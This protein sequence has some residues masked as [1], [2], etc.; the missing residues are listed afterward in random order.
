MMTTFPS[1]W[2]LDHC[3]YVF[4]IEFCHFF[5][6]FAHHMLSQIDD[7]FWWV[8]RNESM[9]LQSWFGPS[10]MRT[11]LVVAVAAASLF[12]AQSVAS[13]TFKYDKCKDCVDFTQSNT[14]VLNKTLEF[15][16]F[17]SKIRTFECHFVT[18]QGMPLLVRHNNEL[19]LLQEWRGPMRIP[20]A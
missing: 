16:I 14:W 19:C 2:D 4:D 20:H 11:P 7:Q 17:Y 12:M 9:I 1:K 10:A 3:M 18:I 8:K 15:I 5:I 13:W 6:Y